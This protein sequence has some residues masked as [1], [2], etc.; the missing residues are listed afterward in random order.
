MIVVD[1]LRQMG[2]E[3]LDRFV[4]EARAAGCSWSEVGA[5]LGVS[6]QAAQ[7][8]FPAGGT[9]GGWPNGVT[10]SVRAAMVVAQEE[11]RALGHNYVGNE[12]LLLGLLA[13]ADGMAGDVLRGLGVSRE[14]ILARTRAH[15]G[16]GPPRRSEAL[17]VTPQLKRAL[18][19]ARAEAR[20]LGDRCAGA[21]HVLLG[22][23]RMDKG[24]APQLLQELG[25]PP[26]RIREEVAARLGVEG[27]RLA[28]PPRRR[29]RLLRRP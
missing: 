23:A 7:Q 26:G 1:E 20:R 29:T 28:R 9:V 5:V 11:S 14:A 22:I 25:A 16:A 24:F 17:C 4:A 21:E 2:E 12:H 15:V 27:A 6:K 19:E 13:Q 18:D 3:V 10:D 8:R